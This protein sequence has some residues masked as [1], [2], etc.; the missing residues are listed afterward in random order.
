MIKIKPVKLTQKQKQDVIQKVS[1]KIGDQ[2][3]K[4]RKRS[5]KKKVIEKI[6]P[7]Q[8]PFLNAPRPR[9]EYINYYPPVYRDIQNPFPLNYQI[10]RPY[11]NPLEQGRQRDV[12]PNPVPP[13]APVAPVA[14]VGPVAPE[15]PGRT[16]LREGRSRG[17]G[18]PSLRERREPFLP[19]GI[20]FPTP[21]STPFQDLPPV[22]VKTEGGSPVRR[23]R[24]S[25]SSIKSS[26]SSPMPEIG[27]RRRRSSTPIP[28]TGE[29]KFSE[30]GT[31]VLPRRASTPPPRIGEL[32]PEQRPGQS[33]AS[34]TPRNQ[35]SRLP[36]RGPIPKSEIG[37]QAGLTPEETASQVLR[38]GAL[39]PLQQLENEYRATIGRPIDL[40]GSP[41]PDYLDWLA[42][43]PQDPSIDQY[44]L[45]WRSLRIV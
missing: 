34:F 42:S 40:S 11:N 20:Q 3:K 8:Q 7:Q 24:S 32:F 45:T 10:P 29:E 16:L 27:Y 23:R 22:S 18:I 39:T 35:P 21:I 31:R 5:T 6:P 9:L 26:S 1:I 38:L 14:P 2:L 4:K 13:V 33:F 30:L 41:N 37:V 44:L 36:V 15:R 17:T 28:V 43:Q 25:A 19:V 12:I